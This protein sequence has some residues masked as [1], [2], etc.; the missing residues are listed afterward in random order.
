M[1]NKVL[2]IV[3]DALRP[4]SITKE[5]MPT[6]WDLSQRGVRF[7]NH[8]TCSPSK[9]RVASATIATGCYPA[10]HGL[11]NNQLYCGGD[12]I[13]VADY[14][15]LMELDRSAH[16]P[17]LGVPT[18]MERLHQAGFKVAQAT[19]CSSGASLLQNPAL[20][21]FSLNN[22]SPDYVIPVE[23]KGEIHA[24]F[25]LSPEV[26]RPDFKRNQHVT[27][28]LTEHIIPEL[29]PDMALIWFSD[30][31]KSQHKYAPGAPET[32]QSLKAVDRCIKRILDRLE[33]QGLLD[34]TNLL[35][36]S[37]HGFI[38]ADPQGHVAKA[39]ELFPAHIAS[40]VTIVSGN[41]I[42][43]NDADKSSLLP[44]VV[45][46]LQQQ[47]D[48]GA[49]FSD[50]PKTGTLA[51]LLIGQDH[52]RSPD[53]LFY[54][55]W[56]SEPN[57]FGVPGIAKGTVNHG[58]GGT[59][60]YETNVVLIAFGPNFKEN[61]TIDSPTGNIDIAPTVLYLFGQPGDPIM[62]GRV[63][64]E[65][66]KDGISSSEIQFEDLAFSCTAK[67]RNFT[68]HA[69]AKFSRVG[70]TYYFRSANRIM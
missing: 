28:V 38:S 10:K 66:L 2:A 26:Q 49:I 25:G 34:T 12:V 1:T 32:I 17:L 39:K 3:V 59:S 68:Y 9:T 70:N 54:P 36:L 33:E 16:G 57:E 21:G 48:V 41:G 18:L 69:E 30:P 15:E 5:T 24:R 58:H 65:G 61:T 44:E 42:F 45:R 11:V 19:A 20:R 51:R 4:D 62:D 29:Q 14:R 46:C 50:D 40:K 43:I 13:S 37:D 56:T 6:L 55:R 7:R 52:K 35:I 63:L 27:E 64:A 8:F 47:K 67:H 31:D 22:G 60:P 23:K 53:V